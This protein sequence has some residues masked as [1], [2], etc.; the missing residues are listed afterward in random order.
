[1]GIIQRGFLGEKLEASTLFFFFLNAI[2]LLPVVFVI[3][4]ENLDVH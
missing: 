4:A 1:M 2:I 3:Y